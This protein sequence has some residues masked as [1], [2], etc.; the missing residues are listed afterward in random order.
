MNV[1]KFTPSRLTLSQR[2]M[3]VTG[4]PAEDRYYKI[5]D[6]QEGKYIKLEAYDSELIHWICA[7]LNDERKY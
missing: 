3:V 5:K 1:P 2:F 7:R 4:G 6:T